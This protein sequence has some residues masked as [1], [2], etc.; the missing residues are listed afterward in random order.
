MLVPTGSGAAGALLSQG[1][2]ADATSTYS[3]YR[4]AAANDGSL[5]TRWMAASGAYPQR[6][7]VDLGASKRLG[8]VTVNWQRANN[9]VYGYRIVASNDREDW[10]V[11]AD[12]RANSTIGLTSDAVSGSYRYVRVK[13]LTPPTA[14]PRSTRSVFFRRDDFAKLDSAAGSGRDTYP[15]ADPDGAGHSYADAVAH[16]A[17]PYTV[18]H[19]RRR[20]PRSRRRRPRHPR[21]PPG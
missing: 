14:G 6:W 5:T 16:S 3:G 20:P 19:T 9:R 12:R 17:H 13:V 8:L 11:L 4:P 2:P 15:L 21:P 18:G 1:R 10:T 7:T